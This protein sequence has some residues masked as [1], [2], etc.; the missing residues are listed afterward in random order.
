MTAFLVLLAGGLGAA[1]RYLAER[2]WAGPDW[3]RGTFVVNVT[4]CLALGLLLGAAP[5][6]EVVTV[7]G[8]GLVGA[9]TTFSAYAVEIVKVDAERSRAAAAAYALGSVGCGVLAAALGLWLGRVV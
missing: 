5:S 4:G 7:L 1:L 3:P 6:D 9:Y 2:R 8:V